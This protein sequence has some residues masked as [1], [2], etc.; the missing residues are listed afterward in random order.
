MK[1]INDLFDYS[2]LK[3][4]QDDQS[5][6]FSLDSILLAEFVDNVDKSS[7]IL[8]LC[9]GNAAVSLILSYYYSNQIYSF[10]IQKKI[11]DYALESIAL[12]E[13]NDQIHIINDDINNIKNYFPG[14]NF[15]I[16]VANPPYFKFQKDSIINQN[17]EK[18]IARHEIYLKLEDLFQVVTYALKENGCFYM[19]HLPERLEEILFLC[20]KYKLI[21]KKI[22]FVYTKNAKDA[23]IVL[24]KCVKGAR[25]ALVVS[26]P[27][28][29]TDYK[30][31]QN[32]FRR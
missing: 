23:N 21:A 14:N 24:V 7:K 6:K 8:D 30:S 17:I 26:S 13:K 9:A 4:V 11:Y 18:S 25:N 22:Q 3:I 19:V 10:E 12:N 16:V 28:F 15:D 31:Y 27:I 5:F 2:N 32:I 20:E 29:I 1:V